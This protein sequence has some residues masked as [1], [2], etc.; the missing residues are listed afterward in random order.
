MDTGFYSLDF[1]QK[2]K[3]EYESKSPHEG[4]LGLIRAVLAVV[5]KHESLIDL[6][7]GT[8]RHV[9]MLHK[10]GYVACGVDGTPG[11]HALTEGHITQFN[12]VSGNTSTI[13]LSSN[14]PFEWGLFYD[15]GEHIPREY[16]RQLINNICKIP[17]KGLIISWGSPG[18]KGKDH[19]NLRTQV[20]IACEFAKRGWMP[21]DELTQKA[22]DASQFK[23]HHIRLFVATRKK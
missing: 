5:P 19:V 13:C 21:D 17:L 8:G 16:E 3:K 20:Y 18:E 1:Q 4:T 14:G 12:L 10:E 11:I 2:K 7:A 15:V 9:K 23:L 6:G 22:R